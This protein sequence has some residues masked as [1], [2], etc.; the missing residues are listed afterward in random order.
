[1]VLSYLLIVKYHYRYAIYYQILV[2]LLYIA[3][4]IY[5]GTC[6][7]Q[8]QSFRWL[9]TI[10]FYC[11]CDCHR[12]CSKWDWTWQCIILAPVRSTKQKQQI[13]AVFFW[14]KMETDLPGFILNQLNMS[15]GTQ[16]FLK[17]VFLCDVL[18]LKMILKKKWF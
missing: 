7:H 9:Y 14:R 15:F 17:I 4:D 3:W 18:M 6:F 13:Y 5:Q 8:R 2:Q 12:S 10:E 1:L 11:N 16:F